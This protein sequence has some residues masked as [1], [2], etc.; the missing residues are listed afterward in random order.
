M[1]WVVTPTETVAQ[2]ARQC[3]PW[4]QYVAA[5]TCLQ[6]AKTELSHLQLGC[7][8]LGRL[9]RRLLLLLHLL[10]L[11]QRPHPLFTSVRMPA[12]V[13]QVLLKPAG[14]WKQQLLA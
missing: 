4:T 9:L 12:G 14:A 1:S 13:S 5:H 11:C 3:C 6:L 10:N 8:D 7:Y 2:V